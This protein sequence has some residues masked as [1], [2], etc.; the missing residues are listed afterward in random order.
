MFLWQNH[1]IRAKVAQEYRDGYCLQKELSDKYEIS[2]STIWNW[3][4]VYKAHG[5]NTFIR[6]SGN[7][8]YSKNFKI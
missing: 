3:I 8:H 7:K 4:N 2:Q 1:P 6:V 5:I